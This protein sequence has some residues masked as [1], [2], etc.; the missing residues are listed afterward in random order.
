MTAI[1]TPLAAAALV[2]A[3]VIV[4]HGPSAVAQSPVARVPSAT[5]APT[6]V[7]SFGAAT[8][9]N[10]PALWETVNG[11]PTMFL[12]TSFNGWS[13]RLAGIQ[14]STL[15]AVGRVAFHSPP[16][17]GVWFEA[18]LPDVDGTWY[19]YY[20]NERPADVCGD[21]TRMLP[22]IGAAR[23]TDFGATWEDLGTILE[24]P[25]D[26]YD[27]ATTNRYFVGGVGD[28]SAILDR[29]SRYLYFFF[30]Q[31]ADR[32]GS[33]G[34]AIA[35]M[36][37]AFRDQPRGRASVWWRGMVW[38]PP[39][40]VLNDGE[41]SSTEYTYSPGMPIYR[42][43][44]DWH[45]GQ[46]VDAFWGPSV[47]WNTFL[48]Q[49]VMLLNRAIDA[50]WRQEGIYVAFS[51]TLD[52]PRS[53]STPRRLLAGGDWYPQVL[54]LAAGVGTDK[55]AGEQARLF[56]GGRSRYVITFSR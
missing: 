54:G 24:A 36:P 3:S 40:R 50:D 41:V 55:V 46:T 45:S 51:P 28:F 48:E 21:V 10:S 53:W 39:R 25:P 43:S 9:S 18:I 5:L 23:S 6:A 22:R 14:L 16:P 19:G 29:E 1:R 4:S 52:D 15:A 7:I 47:H 44:D 27:C 31:Y 35:R 17:H 34:V 8:D 32:E 26:S 12:F 13:T 49:Y 30:S 20:H 2:A 56:I 33:Q 11:R 37:W 42:V 38:V